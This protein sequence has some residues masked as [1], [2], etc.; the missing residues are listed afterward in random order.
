M[1][2]RDYQRVVRPKTYP[3]GR[4]CEAKGCTTRLNRYNMDELCAL[5]EETERLDK[6]EAEAQERLQ[7]ELMQRLLE[8]AR[9]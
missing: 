6:F 3:V 7:A 4:V 1:S 9:G 5:C 8:E 2:R